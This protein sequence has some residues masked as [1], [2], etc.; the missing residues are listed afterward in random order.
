MLATSG[1]YL[2]RFLFAAL[3]IAPTNGCKIRSSDVGK[4]VRIR[5]Y[6]VTV[7]AEN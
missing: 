4:A 7:Y 2:V 3:D 5:H 6:P 1:E